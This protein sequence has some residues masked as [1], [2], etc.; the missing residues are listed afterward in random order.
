MET[1][2][3]KTLLPLTILPLLAFAQPAA[4]QQYGYGYQDQGYDDQVD[5]YTYDQQYGPD[6]YASRQDRFNDD[7]YRAYRREMARRWRMQHGYPPRDANFGYNNDNGGDGNVPYAAPIYPSQPDGQGKV[8]VAPGGKNVAETPSKKKPV[9]PK[10]A[11]TTTA[12]TPPATAPVTTAPVTATTTPKAPAT[13][14]TVATTTPPAPA[15]TPAAPTTATASAAPAAAAPAKKG[16]PVTCDK[17]VGIVSS[18]GF[19]KVAS[20][21]CDGPSLVYSAERGGKPFEI[22]VNPKTGELTAVKKL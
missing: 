1:K 5:T 10:P 16:G 2:M 21:T 7:Q 15:A 18:F 3:L 19:D 6:P 17:G 14:T 12:A 22:E 20:K 13:T 8:L 11:T 9:T 4:A